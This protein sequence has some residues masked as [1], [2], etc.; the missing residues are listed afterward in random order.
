MSCPRCQNTDFVKN[1]F[2]NENQHYTGLAFQEQVHYCFQKC[3]DDRTNDRLIS[4]I[5][6]QWRC[7]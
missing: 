1:R 4:K 3:R 5:S 7:I 6:C 2:V